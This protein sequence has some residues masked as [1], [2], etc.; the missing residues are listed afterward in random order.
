M[1]TANNNDMWLHTQG[2]PG[3]HV[4]IEN[5]GGEVS[6]QSIEEAAVIAACFSKAGES[7][8]V[9]VDYTKVRFLKKPIGAK[10]GKVIYHEYYT[11]IVKPDKE[12]C[13]KLRIK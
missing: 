4:I 10:P 6:D 11:I 1:K 8:L 5:K 9:P 2:F 12:L 3:S 7:S 13:E